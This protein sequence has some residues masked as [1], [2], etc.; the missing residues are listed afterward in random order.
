MSALLMATACA[1]PEKSESIQAAA[2]P[3]DRRSDVPKLGHDE[4]IIKI[5][6]SV[7]GQPLQLHLFGE[8]RDPIF[9]F[10]GI[11][12]DEPTSVAVAIDLLFLLRENP[13]IYAEA[14]VAI[15]PVANPDGFDLRTRQNFNGVDCN[16]NFPTQNWAFEEEKHRYWGGPSPASEPETRAI[17]HAVNMLEPRIIISI[18][19]I[20]GGR[21]Q[22]NYDGPADWL[23][24]LMSAHNGYPPTSTIG[25]ATP[26]SFGTWAGKELHIPTITL[27]LPASASAEEAWKTNRDALLAA[28]RASQPPSSAATR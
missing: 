5:G 24:E 7:N 3:D 26:G 11:H 13:E 14:P 6:E 25:Y 15:L 17:M 18:H 12:G 21:Q 20:S 19:S 8:P 2:K 16:R 28:I 9:I 23:A 4:V 10:G 22:N 27:E 1:G